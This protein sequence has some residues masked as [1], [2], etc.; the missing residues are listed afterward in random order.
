MSFNVKVYPRFRA[1][2]I[3][4][5]Y[6]SSTRV[7]VLEMIANCAQTCIMFIQMPI[8]LVLLHIPLLWN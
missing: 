5:S 2:T 3:S 6:I 8:P 7:R 4:Y 1:C